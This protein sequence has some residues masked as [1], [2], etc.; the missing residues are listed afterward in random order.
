MDRI[1]KEKIRRINN[2]TTRIKQLEI[3]IKRS[4][5][6]ISNLTRSTLGKDFIENSKIKNKENITKSKIEIEELENLIHDINQGLYDEEID[7]EN[8]KGMAEQDAKGITFRKNKID[9]EKKFVEKQKVNYEKRREEFSVM[10]DKNYEMERAERHYYKAIDRLPDYIAKNLKSM[11]NNKGYIFMDVTFLGELPRE[12]GEHDIYFE[13]QRDGSLK[14]Y[15]Y[16]KDRT[17]ISIKDKNG[18]KTVLSET[19]RVSL[20]QRNENLFFK[21]KETKE[22]FE[23]ITKETLSKNKENHNNHPQKERKREDRNN[24]NQI[25]N[26][27]QNKQHKKEYNHRNNNQNQVETKEEHNHQNRREYNHQN[28]NQNNQ[29]RRENNHQN[30]R[31]NNHQNQNNQNRRENNQQNQN[32]QNRRENN[33]QNQNNQNRRENNQQNQNNQ[34]RRENNQQNRKNNQINQDLRENKETS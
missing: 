14:I 15:E 2:A 13:K 8:K 9:N 25:E 7:E 17:K 3:S 24:N 16:F 5:E 22:K 18:N 20:I 21:D 31:E 28:Q 19:P 32:N 11:P 6:A 10:K 29:N 33:Q 1:E 23:E 4:E 30:R 12:Q 26:N 27:R 34:N